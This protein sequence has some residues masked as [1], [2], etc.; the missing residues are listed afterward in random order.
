MKHRS[1]VAIGLTLVLLAFVCSQFLIGPAAAQSGRK[2]ESPWGKKKKKE[3]DSPE[4]QKRAATTTSSSDAPDAA[5]Q[6]RA[7]GWSGKPPLKKKGDQP[8]QGG[9]QDAISLG[10]NVVNVTVVVYDKKSGKIYTGLKKENFK[11]YEDGVEQNLSN[12]SPT[13]SPITNVVLLEF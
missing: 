3:M 8:I 5:A 10:T 13:E 1:G 11:I 9:D 2:V 6:G 4:K 7:G 12:F